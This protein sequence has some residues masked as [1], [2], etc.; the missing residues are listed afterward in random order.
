M[1]T[2]LLIRGGV[3]RRPGTL[4]PIELDILEV[5]IDTAAVGDG[6]LHGYAIAKHISQG[7][8]ARPLTAHGTLYKALARLHEAGHLEHCWEE[9]E[10][11]LSEGRPR[12]RLYRV[13]G[14]GRQAYAAALDADPG[15]DTTLGWAPT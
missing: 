12:R 11:A 4:L 8:D 2:Y 1:G 10:V 9:P 6:W 13:T 3:R 15:R 14:L 7:R 5:S